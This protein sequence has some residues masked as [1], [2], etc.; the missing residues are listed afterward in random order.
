LTEQPR[1][2]A[3]PRFWRIAPGLAAFLFA[4]AAPWSIAASQTAVVL[5]AI[6]VTA[7]LFRERVPVPRIPLALVPVL[8]FLGFQI[9]SIP[10][11][12]HPKGSLGLLKDSWTLLFPFF[13]L[14]MLAD[15]RTS[16]RAVRAFVASAALAGIVGLSQHLAGYDWLRP[17]SDWN[18]RGGGFMAVGSFGGHLTY[19]GVLLPAFFAAAGLVLMEQRRWPWI[20][21]LAAI[22]VGLLFSYARTAWLGTAAGLLLFGVLGRPPKGVPAIQG[23]GQRRVAL[24]AVAGALVLLAL[25][26][27]LDSS[28]RERASSIFQLGNDPRVRLWGTA[29]RITTGPPVPLPA[30]DFQNRPEPITL[31]FGAGLGAFKT[32]F[33]YYRLP[34]AYMSTTDPHS[35]ILNHLVE[36]GV[37][38]AAAWLSIWVAFFMATRRARSPLVDGLRCGVAALLV[39]GLGQCFSTDEEVAQAWWFVAAAALVLTRSPA[40]AALHSTGA[41][42]PAAGAAP[43][44]GRRKQAWRK[45]LLH[46]VKAA[47]LA[48]AAALLAARPLPRAPAVVLPSLPAAPSKGA[49]P[50]KEAVPS[51]GA[52][53]SKGAAR[54]LV[55]RLDNRLGNL[56]LLTPFLQ[57]LREALP[58]AHLGF[59]SG[60]MFAPMLRDWPWIDEWIVQPKRRHAAFP[61][62]F[63][64]W[65]AALRRRGW[66]LAFEASNPDTHSFYNCLLALAAGA[67]ERIG[68]DHPRSRRVLTTIV[69][70]PEAGLH[71]SLAPLRLLRALGVEAPA[72]PMRC[73]TTTAPSPSF[74]AWKT[75]EGIGRGHLVVHLGGRSAKAW[76]EEGWA[77]LLPE[78]MRAA[79][80]PVVLVAGPSEQARLADLWRAPGPRPLRAPLLAGPD[81]VLLLR[82]AAGFVGCDSGVMHLAV[83]VG[84]PTTAMFFHSNPWHYAPLGIEHRTVLLADPFGVDD[85]AWARPV[86]GMLRSPIRRAGTPHGGTPPFEGTADEAAS[87]AGIP[88]TGP[89]ATDAILRALIGASRHEGSAS[90][91]DTKREASP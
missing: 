50:S 36:T 75:R 82:E 34:G 24:F 69:P 31:L 10:M 29:L 46:A 49:A 58:A 56:L 21:A 59:A 70:T 35:D 9:L 77:R 83:A 65:V 86:E 47:I 72:A 23:H 90:I 45:D 33:P 44:L 61:P 32:L 74:T 22:G 91:A 52:A 84:T 30:P 17:G 2:A 43:P 55:V 41:M 88:E 19:A 40:G 1:E 14:A 67:P 4:I 11:G 20:L 13:F 39:G 26:F 8:V 68:F 5:G 60:E 80:G 87:R 6:V 25:V 15:E 28:L 48:A 42:L 79:A 85:E 38:G 71:F 81:L 12:V 73:P 7:G 18:V 37:L 89:A 57:R 54:I 3:V 78:L 51:E 76:P 63:P 66:D 27:L 62:L 16:R 53:R 64:P